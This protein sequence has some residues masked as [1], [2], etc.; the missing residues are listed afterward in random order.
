MVSEFTR[1]GGAEP[2]ANAE[3]PD[4]AP[5]FSRRQAKGLL[6]LSYPIRLAV[7]LSEQR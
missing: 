2:A 1:K 5:I 6:A 3:Y 4:M 7:H